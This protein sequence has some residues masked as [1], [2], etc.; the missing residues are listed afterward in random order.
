MPSVGMKTSISWNIAPFGSLKGFI[1]WPWW[2]WHF[3]PKIQLH[4]NGLKTK[5]RG[6]SP[7]AKYT[8]RA[9]RPY[10]LVGASHMSNNRQMSV[11]MQRL[12]DFISMVTNSTLLR[13][14]TVTLLLAGV[15]VGW[16]ILN[17]PLLCNGWRN[18]EMTKI[19]SGQGSQRK[20]WYPGELVDWL[21][22]A[23][24]TPTPTRESQSLSQQQS[25][26]SSEWV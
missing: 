10:I 19:T 5:L 6:L 13:N 9:T 4:F 24:R 11:A 18:Y 3:S 12:V 8:D 14:N 2:W 26:S 23:R 7:R 16:S 1:L 25:Q 17:S 22:A 15:S 20:A 21:S